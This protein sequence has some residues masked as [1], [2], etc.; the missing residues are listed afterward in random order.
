MVIHYNM[1]DLRERHWSKWFVLVGTTM[2]LVG[3]T[4]W[5]AQSNVDEPD[6]RDE[7]CTVT[8]ITIVTDVDT[9]GCAGEWGP[10]YRVSGEQEERRLSGFSYVVTKTQ[11]QR[12]Q[13]QS[14][15][16]CQDQRTSTTGELSDSDPSVTTVVTSES[17]AL[18]ETRLVDPDVPTVV[19]CT[20][21][22]AINFNPLAGVADG[23]CEYYSACTDPL[24]LNYNAQAV[25]GDDSCVYPG[26]GSDR[27]G[28]TDVRAANYDLFAQVDDGSCLYPPVEVIGCM[29]QSA[30]NY[31]PRATTDLEAACV[32]IEEAIYGCTLETALNYNAEATLNDGSCQFCPA[33][34]IM[35]NGV[36]GT[37][38][39]P[40]FSYNP[41]T[42]SCVFVPESISDTLDIECS[43][44]ADF[45]GA[46]SCQETFVLPVSNPTLYVR[47][48]P[49]QPSCT[50]VGWS[51]SV[52]GTNTEPVMTYARA[53]DR[54]SQLV[55]DLS[56][57][58][59]KTFGRT[60]AVEVTTLP[61]CS[62]PQATEN[63]NIRLIDLNITEE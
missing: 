11:E 5:Y 28:C 15:G 32:Y 53:Q 46:N 35:R 40:G 48:T 21:N 38:C 12:S 52:A 58:Y 31:N 51:W 9:I 44:D 57:D 2:L 36:C 41:A 1:I 3:G 6:D 18:V 39:A 14:R 54:T 63:L 59:R 62:V 10:W 20:D 16:W 45:S 49:T 30:L 17:C 42:D 13:F 19:G 23:S 29:D 50:A 25:V 4:Y 22:L 56:T 8:Q 26:G 34:E 47:A 55:F 61:G 24:A 37:P 33:G 27:T 7:A 43:I 60:V